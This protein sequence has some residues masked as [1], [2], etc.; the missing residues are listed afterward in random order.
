MSS[1]IASALGVASKLADSVAKGESG[2]LGIVGKIASLAFKAA[3]GIVAGGGDPVIEITRMLS[4][5][6][7][8]EGVHDEWDDFIRRNFPQSEPP[9]T[10][11]AP[12]PYEEG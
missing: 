12:D 5:K 9:P 2:T 7:E 10:D 8:V 4:P 3:A 6:P 11:P 1:E